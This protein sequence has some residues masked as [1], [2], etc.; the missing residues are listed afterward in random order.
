MPVTAPVV[1]IDR[2]VLDVLMRDLVGHDKKPSAFVVYLHLA[3]RA[4]REMAHGIEA[5]LSKIA[6][7]TGLSKTAVQGAIAHL[8]RREL[9]SVSKHSETSTPI[10]SLKRHWRRRLRQT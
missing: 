3:A 10:Y 7:A 6:A 1:E 9:I 4:E 2:Y 8:K 5:S